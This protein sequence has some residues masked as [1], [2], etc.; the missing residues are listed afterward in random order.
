MVSSIVFARDRPAATISDR[1]KRGQL[2]RIA[3]GVYTTDVE[4]PAERVVRREW[5]TIVGRLYPN[6]VITDRSAPTGGPVDGVLYIARPGRERQTRLPG[7]L[8]RARTGL[9][10]LAG[11]TPLPGSLVQASKPRALLENTAVSRARAGNAPR[12]LSSD[13]L[14]DWVDRLAM[15]EGEDRL[16]RYRKEV[17][18]LAEML[19]VPR[20]RVEQVSQLIGAALGT[21][22][23][24]TRSDALAARQA[25][26]PYDR[27]RLR[28]F[29][30][31][32]D[33]LH[34]LRVIQRRF[35]RIRAR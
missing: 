29:G 7:L 1:V 24:K 26:R 35:D 23:V 5:H 12:T 22:Q 6:A 3:P 25:G 8:V 33:A 19:G 9:G 31:L 17:E 28:L 18:S 2:S 21:Q 15:V 11:D 32:I 30:L 4:S 27:D 20:E 16:Q 34:T 14:A 13:E 10:P